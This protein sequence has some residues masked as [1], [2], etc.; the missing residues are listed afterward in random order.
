MTGIDP[1]GGTLLGGRYVRAARI[2]RGPGGGGVVL[3]DRDAG[4]RMAALR[5]P[6]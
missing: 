3:L 4:T 5:G 2:R 6:D 1:R